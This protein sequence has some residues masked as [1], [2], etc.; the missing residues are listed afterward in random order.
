MKVTAGKSVS[1]SFF[2]ATLSDSLN[3]AWNQTEFLK[4]MLYFRAGVSK[5]DPGPTMQHQSKFNFYIKG[6]F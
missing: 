1:P 6:Q 4:A 2:L 3:K 5:G